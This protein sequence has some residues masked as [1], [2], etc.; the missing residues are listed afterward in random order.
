MNNQPGNDDLTDQTVHCAME[1]SSRFRDIL[2]IAALAFLATK[3]IVSENIEVLRRSIFDWD[4]CWFLIIPVAGIIVLLF[5]VTAYSAIITAHQQLIDVE[6]IAED[7]QSTGTG[8]TNKIKPRRPS[9]WPDV[10]ILC[11]CLGAMQSLNSALQAI[12]NS[13]WQAECNQYRIRKLAD[14][15]Q[16]VALPAILTKDFDPNNLSDKQC[17]LIAKNILRCSE[18]QPEFYDNP[19]S[20][21]PF[22]RYEEIGCILA[23]TFFLT[24]FC[25]LSVAKESIRALIAKPQNETTEQQKDTAKKRLKTLEISKKRIYRTMWYNIIGSLIS[26][27]MAWSVDINYLHPAEALMGLG[28]VIVVSFF[29]GGK[30]V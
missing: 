10:I 5:V 21:E 20:L 11:F 28:V 3:V 25:R 2:Y 13:K 24:I 23:S 9:L 27:F 18:R 6:K 12:P 29:Y 1:Y 26:T 30:N 7:A 16:K 4:L 17:V 19:C 8:E 22:G 14:S 15:I